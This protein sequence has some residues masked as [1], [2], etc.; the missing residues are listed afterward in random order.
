MSTLRI[1]LLLVLFVALAGCAAG[2]AAPTP[3]PP[4]G[5]IKSPEEAVERV[6]AANPRFAG[7]RERDPELIGQSH[8]FEVTPA[9]GVGAY[10]VTMR[11][12]WGDCPAGCIDEHRWVY[13]VGPDGTVTL[14]TETGADVPDDVWPAGDVP[15][16]VTG[17]LVQALAGPVC[18]VEQDPP[19][20][21]CAP[22]PVVGAIVRVLDGQGQEIAAGQLDATGSALIPVAPGAYVVVPEA[23]EGLMGTPGPQDVVVVD[24]R[25][26][27]VALAYDTGIR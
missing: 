23:V 24:G 9:S 27:P 3:I 11:I 2:G 4:G 14:Q 18:P 19:D 1:G 25:A 5:T 7:I 26:T 13:A 15:P 21:A 10:V 20:P 16:G 17:V 22:R 6:V 8:W 12:G